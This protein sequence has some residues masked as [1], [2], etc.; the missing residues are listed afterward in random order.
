MSDIAFVILA[1][2]DPVHV[3]RLIAALDDAPVIL[4]C[5]AK[6]PA[7]IAGPMISN[8]PPRVTIAP[9]QRIR[10]ASWSLVQA[11][12]QGLRLALASTR[13]RHV[14]VLSG[15]DYPLTS[16]EQLDHELSAWGD[17]SWMF[18]VPLPHEP[19]STPWH[20][21][22]GRWRFEYRFFTI[23]DQIVSV[24]D[25]PIA[26]PYR[27]NVPGEL[28][29]RASSQWKIYGRDHAEL[30]LRIIDRRPDLIRYWRKTFI[31]E[32][33]FVAS[34]LA[35]PRLAGADAIVPCQDDPWLIRWESRAGAHPPLL[36]L[37][38][39]PRLMAA[40]NPVTASGPGSTA[41]AGK[42]PTA[43]HPPLFA[44]K[45]SSNRDIAVLDRIDSDLRA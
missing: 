10:L 29:L 34:I 28:E 13:A 42:P 23:G 26:W 20:R 25:R 37:E 24:R 18:N 36:S 44:R 1:H 9:R 39:L 12:L 6:T 11:E 4:H 17:G 33:S 45:F 5:D 27:V 30:L 15:A 38:D 32:E 7:H 35:S 43:R 21:D 40:R 2:S 14:A 31:P 16:M 22:G 41:N 3:R 19:W 8:L